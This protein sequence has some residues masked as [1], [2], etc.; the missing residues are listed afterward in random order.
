MPYVN[1]VG[2]KHRIKQLLQQLPP[3]DNEVRYGGSYFKR[4]SDRKTLAY[5]FFNPYELISN[6]FRWDG[7]QP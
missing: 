4:L 6:Q 5:Y 2:E 3:H 7:F 1:S